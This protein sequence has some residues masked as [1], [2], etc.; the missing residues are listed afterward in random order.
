MAEN[1]RTVQDL[2]GQRDFLIGKMVSSQKLAI[3]RCN[4]SLRYAKEKAFKRLRDNAFSSEFKQL[5]YITDDNLG[6]MEDLKVR[7]SFLENS[8]SILA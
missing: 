8:N 3:I 2:K 5:K 6:C 4:F 1:T 7:I